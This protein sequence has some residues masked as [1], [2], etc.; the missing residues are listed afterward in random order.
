M[1][2]KRLM[3]RV[4]AAVVAVAS[5]SWPLGA[6]AQNYPTRPIKLIANGSPGG[7]IDTIGRVTASTLAPL[8]GTQV[9]VENRPG[10][11]SIIGTQAVVTAP[12]DGYTLLFTGVDGMGILPSPMKQMPYDPAKDLIPI[13][14]VTQ[15]DVVLAVGAHLKASSV[16]EF[17][18]LA[19]A[20]P[21]KLTF[22]STGLGTMTH[23]AGEFLKLRAGIDMLHVPYRG[24][25]P[26]VTDL[27]GGRVD[28]VFTG[29]ATAAGHVANGVKVIASAGKRRPTLMPDVPT[30]IE[31]GYPDYYAGSWFGVMAPAGT[32]SDVVSLLSQK[33]AEVASS[34][35]FQQQ[36]SN[37]GSEQTLELTDHFAKSLEA[38]RT[39][40][41]SIAKEANVQITE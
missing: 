3:M 6:I 36:L 12:P 9:V 7:V 14:K 41:K 11:S 15:V 27:L 37:L 13:A 24:S 32:P 33:L 30:V 1:K 25:A 28:M 19:K 26:A 29:V 16:R 20:N 23:M 10:A 2:T 21:G 5:F 40:W 4:I 34:A 22:G 35:Q 8:I 17:V 38:E 18:D 39:L 31:S